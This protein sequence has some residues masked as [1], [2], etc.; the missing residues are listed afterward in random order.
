MKSSCQTALLILFCTTANA[1]VVV[2]EPTP[3][4]DTSFEGGATNWSNEVPTADANRGWFE[5]LGSNQAWAELI[6]PET[7]S[8]LPSTPHGAMWAGFGEFYNARLYTQIGT[9]SE[10]GTTTLRVTGL[11]GARSGAT[12]AWTASDTLGVEIWATPTTFNGANG[13]DLFGNATYLNGVNLTGTDIF[14]PGFV[15]SE[16]ESI[17]TEFS[18]DIDVTL[19]AGQVGYDIWLS[20]ASVDTLGMQTGGAAGKGQRFFDNPGVS[21]VPEPS[22]LP[23][24]ALCLVRVAFR[25]R[26]QHH[27]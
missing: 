5:A 9:V 22:S 4:V 14:G 12:F 19:G 8:L 23:L 13:T 1:S 20:I 2:L 26:R 10:A 27:I 21:I 17:A 3:I 11:A 25:R 15:T 7:D 18:T 24:I 16:S 6:A